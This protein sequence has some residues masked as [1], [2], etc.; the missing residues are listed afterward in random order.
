MQTIRDKEPNH[1]FMIPLLNQ[2]G[3]SKDCVFTDCTSENKKVTTVL[4]FYSELY[5]I[6]EECYQKMKKGSDEYLS[7]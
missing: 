3:L 2:W 1:I 7:Q 6:C 5:A 4:D